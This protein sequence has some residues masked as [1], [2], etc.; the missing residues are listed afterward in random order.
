MGNTHLSYRDFS[1]Y[2]KIKTTLPLYGR[3]EFEFDEDGNE[4]SSTKIPSK[5]AFGD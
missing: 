3:V 1:N 2:E 5:F 4:I